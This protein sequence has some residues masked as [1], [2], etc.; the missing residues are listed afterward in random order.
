MGA[1][2]NQIFCDDI[3]K[4]CAMAMENEFMVNRE[5]ENTMLAFCILY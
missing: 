1:W 5:I 2:N 3:H 4:K